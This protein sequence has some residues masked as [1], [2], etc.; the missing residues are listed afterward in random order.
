MKLSN[1]LAGIVAMPALMF[2]QV[3]PA[4]A[5]PDVKATFSEV[6]NWIVKS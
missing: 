3:T 5:K 4:P 1:L 2:A 6:P